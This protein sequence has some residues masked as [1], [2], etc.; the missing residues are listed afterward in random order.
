MDED[1][2]AC[3]EFDDEGM[4]MQ[5]LHRAGDWRADIAGAVGM[6]GDNGNAGADQLICEDWVGNGTQTDQATV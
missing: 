1:E 2:G 3:L 6:C 4:R 5:C